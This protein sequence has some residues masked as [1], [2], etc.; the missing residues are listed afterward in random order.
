[1]HFQIP[2]YRKKRSWSAWTIWSWIISEYRRRKVFFLF[3]AIKIF[4][5]T[6]FD[7]RTTRKRARL[8]INS[9]DKKPRS[10]TAILA[11][12]TAEEKIS[13]LVNTTLSPRRMEKKTWNFDRFWSLKLRFYLYTL[14][15]LLTR[16]PLS[17]RQFTVRYQKTLQRFTSSKLQLNKNA[18]NT[19]LN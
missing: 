14:G 18:K 11:N 1:M 4:I 12:L 6:N 17:E 7:F 10:K 9:T 5:D 19:E 2:C 15:N 3:R 16:K 13:Y 8:R